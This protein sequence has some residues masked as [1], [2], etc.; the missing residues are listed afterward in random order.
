MLNNFIYAQSKAMF[1]ERLAE[2]PNDAI[3]FIEDT[4]EIWT[5]GTYFDCSTLDPNIIPNLQTEI[6]ELKGIVDNNISDGDEVSSLT[7][8][9]GCKIG[10]FSVDSD[11]NLSSHD[12]EHIV[13]SNNS[14]YIGSDDYVDYTT[15]KDGR[16]Q[17]ASE[18]EDMPAMSIIGP[19]GIEIAD[20]L[21]N[22]I[23]GY[24]IRAYDGMFGGLRP[25]VRVIVNSSSSSDKTLTE[26]DHTILIYAS[27]QQTIV[28]PSN[29]KDGQEYDILMSLTNST[30][31]K[32]VV[33]SNSANIFVP[34]EGSLKS[35]LT[36]DAHGCIKLIY[37]KDTGYWWY[38][39][40]V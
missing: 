21:R 20:P 26:L 2:V 30:S 40:M 14:I 3:V 27:S 9:P 11:N 32:H 15:I 25:W 33:S 19:N 12:V 7:L 4:K 5:H 31:V 29:P 18:R 16:L 8:K 22:Q 37:V 6:D 1:E 36:V 34:K 13:I 24:A 38:Y 17:I 23:D 39:R 28:L 10:S 35:S